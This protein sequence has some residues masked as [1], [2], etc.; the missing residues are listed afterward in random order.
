MK[1]TD[2]KITPKLGP[3]NR[4]WVLLKIETDEGI[5]GLGEWSPGASPG[6]LDGSQAAC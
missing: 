3:Q 5:T 4:D 2:V 6:Q 1:I